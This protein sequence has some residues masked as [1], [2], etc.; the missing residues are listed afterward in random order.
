MR[1]PKLKLVLSSELEGIED[2]ILET[3]LLS[4]LIPYSDFD[5]QLKV[6]QYSKEK[7]KRYQLSID[8]GCDEDFDIS[9]VEDRIGA[10]V[11]KY[12]LLKHDL[13]DYG[14]DPK[15]LDKTAVTVNAHD[16]DDEED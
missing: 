16:E 9:K 3:G 11:K 2:K 7:R 5:V 10:A 8:I 1:N 14:I 6:F 4:G 15:L 13:S 12:L